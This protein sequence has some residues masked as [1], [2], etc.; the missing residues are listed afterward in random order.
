MSK[1]TKSAALLSTIT[2]A[3]LYGMR[4]EPIRY[5]D[6]GA[7][8]GLSRPM[9]ALYRCGLV[10]PVFFEAEPA[11]AERLKARYR[12]GSVLACGLWDDETSGTL[13]VTDEPGQSSLLKPL[14]AEIV[15]TCSVPLSRADAILKRQPELAP[16]IVKLDIQDVQTFGVR[17][18]RAGIWGNA[19]YFRSQLEGKR[20][21]KIE[22]VFQS[23]HGIPMRH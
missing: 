10:R 17:S 7:R 13:Y 1:L 22:S 9:Q 8:W 5:W 4:R 23:L 3:S 2:K 15:S 21:R 12:R 6:A 20:Q 19:F 18:T 11:E 16:E 14:V